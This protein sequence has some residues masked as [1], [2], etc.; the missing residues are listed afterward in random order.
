MHNLF[1]HAT[2]HIEVPGE[3][4]ELDELVVAFEDGGYNLKSL[5]VEMVASPAFRMVGDAE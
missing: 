4:S 1:R 2:G 5:M 3:A